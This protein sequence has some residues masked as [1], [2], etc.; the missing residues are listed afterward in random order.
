MATITARAWAV[1]A[2]CGFAATGCKSTTPFAKSTPTNML[3][4]SK[5]TAVAHNTPSDKGRAWNRNDSKLPTVASPAL[6]APSPGNSTNVT[7]VST[8]GTTGNTP[9]AGMNSNIANGNIPPL[10]SDVQLLN[11][12]SQSQQAQMPV[13]APPIGMNG[14]APSPLPPPAT[15]TANG[16]KL[17]EAVTRN[18]MTMPPGL[19][20][21]P[22]GSGMP[23]PAAAP[24]VNDVPPP[25]PPMPA[26]SAMPAPAAQPSPQQMPAPAG[27]MPAPVQLPPIKA[28]PTTGG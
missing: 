5:E 7:T 4:K 19:T 6:P 25:A 15:M 11:H 27:A 23:L 8:A 2:L 14:N 24:P 21:E 16:I 1:I 10:K 18:S 13:P 22:A 3:S 17:P 12:T 26:P 28:R 9:S 20:T